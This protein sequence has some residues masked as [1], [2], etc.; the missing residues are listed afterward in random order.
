MCTL[1]LNISHTDFNDGSISH[2][3]RARALQPTLIL[4][5]HDRQ[6]DR[7]SEQKAIGMRSGG[8]EP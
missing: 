5:A 3:K 1:K 8:Q 4:Q 2:Q 6:A 7:G